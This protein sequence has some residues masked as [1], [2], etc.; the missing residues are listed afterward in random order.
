MLTIVNF[1]LEISELDNCDPLYEEF[2][3]WEDSTKGLKRFSDV[4]S[5]AK[6]YIQIAKEKH[7]ENDLEDAFTVHESILTKLSIK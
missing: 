4:P 7:I 3:G 1:P 6:K 5:N 2:E